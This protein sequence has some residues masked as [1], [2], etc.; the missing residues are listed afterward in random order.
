MI[1]HRRGAA[2]PPARL[3]RA[4]SGFQPSARGAMASGNLS[5]S[6][7]LRHDLRYSVGYVQI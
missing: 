5:P 6:G 7:K 4:A 2:K 3:S 1:E